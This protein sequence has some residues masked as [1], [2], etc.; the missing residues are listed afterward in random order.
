MSR[1]GGFFRGLWRF[2]DGLRRVL[3]LIL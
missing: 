2:L 1:I 3:S